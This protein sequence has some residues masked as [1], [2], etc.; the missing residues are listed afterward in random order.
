VTSLS[1]LLRVSDG[2]TA[3]HVERWVARGLLRPSSSTE[4]G[5]A[6]A[7]SFEPIDVA[8][9]QLLV[10]LADDIGLDDDTVEAVIALIDQVHTLRGQLALLA[11]AI[12]QQ[13]PETR[14]AIAVALKRLGES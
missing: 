7:W 14:E 5:S 1:E 9:V 10:E 4:A 2:L 13:P 11:A 8:R 3:I 12:A 6:E